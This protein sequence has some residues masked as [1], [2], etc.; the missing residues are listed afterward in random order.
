M[1]NYTPIA[2]TSSRYFRSLVGNNPERMIGAG[3]SH[4]NKQYLSLGKID[5]HG[6]F[7]EYVEWLV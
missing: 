4:L 5:N 7:Q 2:Q 1:L 6:K 3:G